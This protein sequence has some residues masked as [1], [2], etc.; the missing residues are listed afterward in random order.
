MAKMLLIV[1]SG[2][3]DIISMPLNF[4][5]NQMGEGNEVRVVFWGPSERTLANRD[6]LR[7]E[8]SLLGSTKPKACINTARKYGLE[9]ELSSDLDLGPIGEYIG[10]CIDE[11]F[12]IVSF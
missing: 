2:D 10:R 5:K 8:Y 11:G 12:E 9:A 4:A 7:R 1:M 6:Q 3:K